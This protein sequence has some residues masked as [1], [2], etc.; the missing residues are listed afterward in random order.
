MQR[1]EINI[2]EKELCVML[3]IY[4]DYNEMHG[5]QNIKERG[6]EGGGRGAGLTECFV[7]IKNLILT[8]SNFVRTKAKKVLCLYFVMFKITNGS[9]VKT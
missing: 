2:H 7:I 5:Q 3:V 4:K 9:F 6:V 8:A 1:I